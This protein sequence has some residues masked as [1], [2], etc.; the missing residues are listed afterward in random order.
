MAR[1]QLLLLYLSLSLVAAQ[2]NFA[3][4]VNSTFDAVMTQHKGRLASAPWTSE[5]N[6]DS[7]LQFAKGLKICAVRVNVTTNPNNTVAFEI[8][9]PLNTTWN[10]RFLTVGN[11]A[12]DGGTLRLDMFAKVVHGWAVMSTNTGHEGTGLSWALNNDQAQIDWAYGAMASSVPFAKDVVAAYYG[13]HANSSYYAGCSTGGR[14]GIRQ[15][16]VDPNSFDGMLIGA[17][18]WNV[19]SAMPVISRIG[20]LGKNYNLFGDALVKR[21]ALQVYNQCNGLDGTTADLTIQDSTPCLAKFLNADIANGSVWAGLECNG[22]NANCVTVQ[23]RQAFLTIVQEFKD[24]NTRNT[25]Y[26]GDG[27]GIQAI[28]DLTTYLTAGNLDG[29]DQDFARYFLPA[30]SRG[31]V[32]DSDANGAKLINASNAWDAR[33][34]ANADPSKLNGWGGKVILYTGT[35]DGLVATNGTRRVFDRAG[36]AGNNNLKYFEIAGMTHCVDNGN[37]PGGVQVP[38]YIGGLGL[39]LRPPGGTWFVADDLKNQT[40]PIGTKETDALVALVDWVE[41]QKAA[42][43]GTT[44]QGPTMIAASSFDKWPSTTSVGMQRWLCAV[45]KKQHFKGGDVRDKANWECV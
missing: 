16:E 28:G 32:W 30:E 17:P 21:L 4:C 27:F 9:M 38:W 15:T 12:F 35:A 22:T 14:M 25:T 33:V 2:D 7:V 11:N 40:F 36:G 10:Q 31:L 29:F 18:A 45:P 13:T 42:P 6:V 43:S 23:Q 5:T 41:R 39:Y 37:A 26:A 34:R 20:W 8:Y 24:P 1:F 44:V 3:K 19:K